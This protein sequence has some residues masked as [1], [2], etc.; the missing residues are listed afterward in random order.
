M[1]MILLGNILSLIGCGLMVAIGFVR[2]KEKVLLYQCVQFTFMSMGNFA[3]GAVSG[4]ISNLLGIARNLVFAKTRGTVWMKVAFL[5]VQI[6]LTAIGWS[7][8]IEI[9]P[10]LATVV[11]VWFLDTESDAVFKVAN[12][13]AMVMWLIYDFYYLNYVAGVFDILTIA[14]NFAAIVSIRR[15]QKA[16]Q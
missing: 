11:F 1:N 2:K 12:I 14:S 4:T 7:G 10:I 3:L 15:Q 8:A 9:L 6:G 13:C 16:P 5:A